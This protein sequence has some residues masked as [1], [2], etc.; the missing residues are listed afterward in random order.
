[1][2]VLLAI[3]VLLHIQAQLPL[4]ALFAQQARIHSVVMAVL[5]HLALLVH[6]VQLLVS[7]SLLVQAQLLVLLESTLWQAQPHLTLL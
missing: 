5:A 4:D 3:M 1:M 6:M 2:F 7:K